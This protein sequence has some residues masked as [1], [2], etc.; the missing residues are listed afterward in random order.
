MKKRGVGLIVAATMS[1][2][3]V[4]CSNKIE[5]NVMDTIRDTPIAKLETTANNVVYVDSEIDV[6]KSFADLEIHT[7]P[8]EPADRKDDW[9][10]LITFNPS[11]KVSEKEEVVVAFHDT[12]VQINSEFYLANEGVEYDSIIEWAKSKYDYFFDV[13]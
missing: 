6:L 7:T 10:Y 12:Y 9:L 13:Y 4:S 2:F 8:L 1:L 5:N 3:F 11:E